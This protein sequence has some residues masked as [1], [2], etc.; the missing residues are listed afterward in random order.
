MDEAVILEAAR[1]LA[2]RLKTLLDDYH[3]TTVTLTREEALLAQGF[4]ESVADLLAS[5]AGRSPA[6]TN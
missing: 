4:A 6:P 5:E 3:A 1:A 2:A